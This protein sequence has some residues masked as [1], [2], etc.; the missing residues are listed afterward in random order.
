VVFKTQSRLL[1]K[2]EALVIA[3]HPDDTLQFLVRPIMA[4]SKKYL[5]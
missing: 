5:D 1:S 3:N 2:R 4:G